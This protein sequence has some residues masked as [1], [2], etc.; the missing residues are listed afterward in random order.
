MVIR[1]IVSSNKA[2]LFDGTNH[3]FWRLKMQTYLCALGFDI[4]EVVE[5][6]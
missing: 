6:G 5:V 3:I 1:E 2:P 4:W